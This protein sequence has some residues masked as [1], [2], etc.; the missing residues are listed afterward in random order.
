[1]RLRRIDA[2][3][4]I[5]NCRVNHTENEG[6]GKRRWS[7]SIRSILF[8]PEPVQY[9]LDCLVVGQTAV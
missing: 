1:M 7:C 9:K 3:D 2:L 8:P 5:L 4:E 6:R